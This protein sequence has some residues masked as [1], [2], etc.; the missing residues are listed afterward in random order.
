MYIIMAS[1]VEEIP[2]E[3]YPNSPSLLT[4]QGYV[5]LAQGKTSNIDGLSSKYRWFV[6]KILTRKMKHGL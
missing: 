3:I 1:V 4:L 6:L 2:A 5:G